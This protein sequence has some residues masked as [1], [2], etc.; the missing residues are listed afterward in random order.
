MTE[1]LAHVRE[2]LF[3][4]VVDDRGNGLVRAERE[5]RTDEEIV[6]LETQYI[7][8]GGWVYLAHPGGRASVGHPLPGR[9][10]PAPRRYFTSEGCLASG[11][12]V[13]SM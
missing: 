3:D 13:M 4:A 9:A 7:V 5:I 6:E 11:T 2:R 10:R 1:S 12:T 8:E